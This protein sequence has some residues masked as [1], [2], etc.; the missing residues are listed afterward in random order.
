[1]E[2]KLIP[3]PIDGKNVTSDWIDEI[4]DDGNC[5]RGGRNMVTGFIGGS[6]CCCWI[7]GHLIFWQIAQDFANNAGCCYD[8]LLKRLKKHD[9][10]ENL[11]VKYDTSMKKEKLLLLQKFYFKDE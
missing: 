7:T 1:M 6:V 8:L 10:D 11:V 4:F 9:D 5:T 3:A 2:K